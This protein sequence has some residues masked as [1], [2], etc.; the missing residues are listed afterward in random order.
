[1]G[2]LPARVR[3]LLLPVAPP[4]HRC[5]GPQVRWPGLPP[6]PLLGV[7][8][9]RRLPAARIGGRLVRPDPRPRS[10]SRLRRHAAGLPAGPRGLPRLPPPPIPRHPHTPDPTP[11]KPPPPPPP[12][13]PPH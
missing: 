2:R 10:R 5:R 1:M 6:G 7:R 13:P 11:P 12:L 3:I 4:G 8:L 9:R